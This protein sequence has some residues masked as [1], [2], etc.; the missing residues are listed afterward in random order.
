MEQEILVSIL[1][2]QER[3]IPVALD[4]CPVA[5]AIVMDYILNVWQ[6]NFILEKEALVLKS[7]SGLLASS[8][9]Y[10]VAGI[11]R[12]DVWNCAVKS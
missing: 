6:T 3:D 9:S 7:S 2:C 8:D 4:T 11:E 10:H 12:G 5:G 1:K